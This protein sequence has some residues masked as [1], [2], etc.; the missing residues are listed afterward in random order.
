M[1]SR[2][3]KASR[4]QRCLPFSIVLHLIEL[5]TTST[6]YPDLVVACLALLMQMVAAP[7]QVAVRSFLD[8]PRTHRPPTGCF[9]LNFS[10]VRQQPRL[11]AMGHARFTGHPP[12]LVQLNSPVTPHR[13]P[14]DHFSQRCQ[15]V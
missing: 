4:T 3:P 8:R 12:Q 6:E 1:G 7:P 9:P 5:P 14:L 2:R 13:L 11:P 10:V 15:L